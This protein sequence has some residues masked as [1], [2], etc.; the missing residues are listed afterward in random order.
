MSLNAAK[1]KLDRVINK[2]RVHFYKPFQLAEILRKHR[3]GRIADL[4]DIESYRSISKKWRDEVSEQLVG[5]ASSSSAKYQ[6][7]VFDENACPPSALVALGKHNA[8]KNGEVDDYIYSMF[9]EKVAVINAIHSRIQSATP[10]D[11]DLVTLIRT[12]E[13]KPGLKRSIDKIYEITVYALFCTIVRA[14][15]L[16]VKLE[17]DNKERDLL[18]SFEHFLASV[19]GFPPGQTSMCH[20]AYLY[21][22]GS[23]NA[24]DRGLDI[25]ASFGA[26]IQVKHLTL[27]GD[28]IADICDG[29]SAERIVIVCKD[30][31]VSVVDAVISQLGLKDRLQGIG[32]FQRLGNL[33]CDL[34]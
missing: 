9:S 1:A 28:A 15:R 25:V 19:L 34:F 22:L 18:Q 31:E 12:F 26:A 10:A 13:S 29:L 27:D 7:N 14:L 5:R 6:D 4:S 24:A 2:S 3:E 33:V 30:A 17:V 11:F 23:T 16:T 8:A 32:D 20:P 21:R